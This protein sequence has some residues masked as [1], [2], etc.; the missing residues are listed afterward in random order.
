MDEKFQT[1]SLELILYIHFIHPDFQ[2]QFEL[3]LEKLRFHLLYFR[4]SVEHLFVHAELLL[5]P[6]TRRENVIY[7]QSINQSITQ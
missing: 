2:E 4:V 6:L 5:R 1:I 3:I 7:N